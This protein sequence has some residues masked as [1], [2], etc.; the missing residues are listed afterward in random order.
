MSQMKEED[1][2]VKFF[3]RFVLLNNLMKACGES[4][5]DL[6]K[7]KKVLRSLTLKF[8]YIVVSVEESKSL[9][10]MKIEELQAL[11]ETFKMRL[12][13]MIFKR[14]KVVEQTLQVKFIKKA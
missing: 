1:S 13:Q 2:I 6:Q 8:D 9:P 5:N 7:I 3:S 14:E 4:I 10:E 11:L 12:K